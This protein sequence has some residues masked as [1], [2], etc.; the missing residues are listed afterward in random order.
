MKT[1]VLRHAPVSFETLADPAATAAAYDRYVRGVGLADLTKD[2]YS[3]EVRNFTT[4]L[5]DQ[6]K[7]DP[8][9]VFTNP[10]ARDYAAR[11]Y[12]RWM[13]TER[14][15]APKGVDLALTSLGS[16]FGWIGLG[17]AN[18]KL[19]AGRERG[20]PKGLSEEQVRDT[21]RA[22]QRRGVRDHALVA[23]ALT[24][25][26]RVSELAALDTT[27]VW[28]SERKGEV[29]VRAGKGDK[30]R[31]VSLI[32]TSRAP[33]ADW[34]RHRATLP[35]AATDALWLARNGERLA[36]R[37]VRYNINEVGRSAGVDLH[38]H[39]LRH[40]AARTLVRNGQDLVTVARIFGWSSIETARNYTDPTSEDMDAAL[41]HLNIDY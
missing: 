24:T 4:W 34:L 18:V 26:L 27:D 14:K 13:L 23:V 15:R 38:P 11:D 5:A 32:A 29:V 10:D 31:T 1:P 2:A 17:P 9:D 40:T 28:V 25:G 8:A 3:R 36:V 22:A 20:K 33:L 39:L 16:L 37:T 6:T 12:R 35:G 41:E 30:P 21:M 7:H 19:V